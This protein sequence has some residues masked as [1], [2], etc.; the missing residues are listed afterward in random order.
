MA[1]IRHWGANRQYALRDNVKPLCD[2]RVPPVR[3]AILAGADRPDTGADSRPRP[4]E[5]TRS[6]ECEPSIL[7][8]L[9]LALHLAGHVFGFRLRRAQSYCRPSRIPAVVVLW[10]RFC[11][12]NGQT[13]PKV[14]IDII[15][16]RAVVMAAGHVP[17]HMR[18]GIA[19]QPAVSRDKSAPFLVVHLEPYCCPR[20]WNRRAL[21]LS[22]GPGVARRRVAF[23]NASGVTPVH[24]YREYG[25]AVTR[26]LRVGHMFGRPTQCPS[27]RQVD[28][29]QKSASTA[30]EQEKSARSG[31]CICVDGSQR[32]E[33]YRGAPWTRR[34]PTGYRARPRPSLGRDGG[35]SHSGR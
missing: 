6:L 25:R 33:D 3:R 19:L 7:S 8:V 24:F 26:G 30:A 18:N 2:S 1:L 11:C 23:V 22:R 15:F 28:A 20:E 21:G 35:A 16:G 4:C 31:P 13:R 14:I 5:A 34:P 9:L 17:L 32:L 12:E 27:R 10:C 29:P